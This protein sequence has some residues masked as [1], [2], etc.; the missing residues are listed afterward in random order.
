MTLTAPLRLAAILSLLA[1]SAPAFAQDE[2]EERAKEPRRYRVGLGPQ[3]FPSYP[4]ADGHVLRPLVDISSA[5]GDTPFEYEA[6]DESF[7]FALVKRGGF[8]IGPALAY[9][10]SRKP[11]DV[12]APVEKVKGTIEAGAFVQYY[13]GENFRLR[14]EGRRGLGGHD[15]WVGNVGA[16]FISRD[17]DEYVFAVG[18]RVSWSNGRYQRAYYGVSPQSAVAT[19]LPLYTPDGGI[20]GVGA[21][22]SIHVALTPRWGLYGYAQYERLVSDAGDSPLVRSFGSR[23]QL[24]GGVA[25]TVTF[26]GGR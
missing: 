8:G 20:Q 12:G 23:N 4:G 15:G 25:L 6:P 22:S 19:G 13:L 14:T 26:G 1:G 17:K 21:T 9:Q 24:S 16:D 18:P 2:G 5:R 7:G 3:L 10:G 11:S